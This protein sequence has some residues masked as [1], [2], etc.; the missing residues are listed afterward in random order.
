MDDQPTLFDEAKPAERPVPSNLVFYGRQETSRLAAEKALPKSGTTR[1]RIY[2]LIRQSTITGSAT[3][4]STS[5][6]LQAITGISPNTMNPTIRGLALDGHIIDS[7][8]RRLTRSGCDAIVW[9]TA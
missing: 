2:Q 5:D 7:G 9:R 3:K 6:E 4:G 1:A 8:E